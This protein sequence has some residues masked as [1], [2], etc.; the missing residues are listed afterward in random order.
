MTRRR[1][2]GPGIEVN[3]NVLPTT[4]PPSR[5][6]PTTGWSTASADQGSLA[7]PP[8]SSTCRHPRQRPF[9]PSNS[10]RPFQFRTRRL[11]QSRTTRRRPRRI[12]TVRAAASPYCF[13]P[14]HL[15]GGS[16][17]AG[18]SSTLCRVAATSV[19]QAQH[20]DLCAGDTGT[21]TVLAQRR[22]RGAATG[23]R[24]GWCSRASD[25]LQ[26]AGSV[27][28]TTA[29]AGVVRGAYRR[30]GIP[31][32]SSTATSKRRRDAAG[33]G[34]R[35]LRW[36]AKTRLQPVAGPLGRAAREA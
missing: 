35:V 14:A 7:K 36:G 16:T 18:G 11:R 6:R 4:S 10:A 31:A 5:R 28:D 15:V 21:P 33:R 25:I 2:S 29:P 34:P 27:P 30:V 3:A 1:R 8:L 24:S 13:R 32:A 19:P 20:H 17:L 22:H 9:P 23:A 26:R 12:L